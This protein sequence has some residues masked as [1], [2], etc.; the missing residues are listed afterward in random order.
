LIIISQRR[1]EQAQLFT[2]LHTHSCFSLLEGLPSPQALVQAATDAGFTAM[3]L[4]DHLNLTGAVQF[5]LACRQ[6]G[7]K[8]V[9][10]LEVDVALP[11]QYGN[12]PMTGPLVL[13]A[14]SLKGWSNLCKISS[15][16]LIHPDRYPALIAPLS[17]IA[18]YSQ[19]LICLTGGLR[20]LITRLMLA[21]QRDAARLFLE[22]LHD[23]FH[24]E[25]YVE[26]QPASPSLNTALHQMASSLSISC[27][28]TTNVYML[29][30]DQTELQQTVTSI[31]LNTPIKNLTADQT[32]PPGSHFGSYTSLNPLFAEFPDALHS[33]Q[34]V[35]DRCSLD[36]PL[37]TPYFPAVPIP[38]EHTPTSYLR[39]KAYAG[40]ARLYGNLTPALTA[41]L[42]H[43]LDTISSLGYEAVFLIVEEVIAFARQASIPTSSRGSAASSLVAHCLSITTPD[44]LDLNLYF[45]RFLNPSRATPP[46][47]DTDICSRR[48]DEI[49]N[50][51]F[52]KYGADRVAMV[53]TINRFRPRS[54]VGDVAKAHGFSP[55]EVNQIT[56]GLPHRYFPFGGS[57][58]EKQDLA[59]RLA[60]LSGKDPDGRLTRVFT[61]AIQLLDLPRHLSMH[62][63]GL[64]VTPGLMTER[65]PVTLSGKEGKIITQLDLDSIEHMG[66]IKIDLLGVRGLTVLGDVATAI[67]TWHGK[68]YPTA[69]DVLDEIP[70]E[71]QPTSETVAAGRTIGCF[72][73]ESPGMRATLRDIGAKSISDIIAA[74][75]LFRPGPLKGGL[76][77]AFVRRHHQ[78]ENDEYLHPS[79]IDLLRESHGVILYQEQVLRIAHEI[80]GFSM[81][82][83]DLLRR[84][85]S[86]F[87]PGRQ[88]QAL[89]EKFIRGAAE[90]RS[91][92]AEAAERIWELMASFAG[93]GFP[94]AH[95][96]S[97]ALIAWRS[98]WC[99]THFP[100]E[101]LAAVLANW[102]GYYSQRVYIAEA[103]RLGIPVRPPNINHS[104]S[105]FR[106]AYP[107]GD[108]VL[109][110]GLDQVRALTHRT[111]SR[112]IQKRPFKT[113]SDFLAS[114]DP[115]PVEVENLIR[116][117]ALAD[118]GSEPDLLD[119]IQHRRWRSGQ[120]SLFDDLL[121]EARQ[122]WTP[123]QKVTGQQEILG[124]SVDYHPLDLFADQVRAANATSTLAATQQVGRK[125]RIAG[126][127]Q[128]WRRSMTATGEM[129]AF[130]TVEDLDGMIDCVVFPAVYR[131]F[132]RE[133][134]ESIHLI[135][136]GVIEQE[137]NRP[138]PIMRVEQVWALEQKR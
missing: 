77:D 48:R 66:L 89:K 81:A 58:Q 60:E 6:A 116:C 120:P 130:I 134:S 24:N 19:D 105:E 109:Y 75:A 127:R 13:L 93:Y 111:Q 95:A 79:L 86:H 92:P 121:V 82:E 88:M 125:L 3:A 110:M 138:D 5:Y 70:L 117:N 30:P 28:G 87:D 1:K 43:E 119:H 115:R 51:L 106:V 52:D 63:G 16:I 68:R 32:A 46:D 59:A 103:R 31:R 71:D 96:A 36:L 20:S 90:R 69:L 54:A 37:G 133:L 55:T 47:I 76:R 39:E 9:I 56:R 2:H 80:A 23:T 27:V 85:M 15:E 53:C 135:L 65:V 11:G 44:P 73:I 122:S 38:P 98:A 61:Q 74:L 14:T 35:V 97:Y 114:V 25:L 62:P 17:L 104:L 22:E 42:D 64:V 26:L 136:E 123:E 100:A 99:K 107:D 84:A 78:T 132:R 108:P 18:G 83:S 21:N 8:P 12:T 33:I 137:E 128:T 129:M 10:G 118:F 126:M 4:T 124:I 131:R 94:K 45:E 29:S 91:V 49:I 57:G 50:H 112:I 40:A 41:R 7:L 72:Q 34:E 101:F 113:L 102:G 67:R